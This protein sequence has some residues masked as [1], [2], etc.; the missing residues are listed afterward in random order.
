MMVETIT[1]LLLLLHQ[2]LKLVRV[3]VVQCVATSA[4]ADKNPLPVADV[5]YK[6]E[7]GTASVVVDFVAVDDAGTV[8]AVVVV[9]GN[10]DADDDEKN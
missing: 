8:V 4:N 6:V 3:V 2:L 9:V 7:S 1:F 10:V 5:S